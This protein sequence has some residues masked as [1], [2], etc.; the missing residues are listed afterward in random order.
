MLSSQYKEKRSRRKIN[1]ACTLGLYALVGSGIFICV[2]MRL[3][4]N[5]IDRD[6]YREKGSVWSIYITGRLP[7]SNS[8]LHAN[9]LGQKG[10]SPRLL[11]SLIMAWTDLSPGHRLAFCSRGTTAQAVVCATFAITTSTTGTDEPVRNQATHSLSSF[12]RLDQ[13]R[14]SGKNYEKSQTAECE[15]EIGLIRKR[16]HQGKEVEMVGRMEKARKNGHEKLD[17]EIRQRCRRWYKT[18][19]EKGRSAKENTR[20]TTTVGTEAPAVP[21]LEETN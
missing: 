9:T 10:N 19:R 14:N 15:K 20:H 18:E 8:K 5:W 7:E 3:W 11:L 21:T 12:S 16:V 4:K 6:T 1:E 17:K 13:L 2:R